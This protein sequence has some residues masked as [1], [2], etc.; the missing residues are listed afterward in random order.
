M[1]AAAPGVPGWIDLGSPDLEATRAFYTGLFGWTAHTGGEEFGGYTIFNLGDDPVAGAGPLFSPDQPTVWTTYVI[2]ADADE[3]AAKVEANGGKVLMAPGDVGENGRM[4]MFMDPGGAMFSVWQPG[5]MP[6]AT[7]FNT[8]GALCWNEVLTRD[9]DGMKAFYGA[10]FGWGHE[11]SQV[12]DVTYT[13]WLLGENRVAGM[14]PMDGMPAEMPAMWATCFAVADT[15]A[16]VAKCVELGGSVQT[17]P[18]D[19]PQ[20]RY[21]VLSDPHGGSFQVIKM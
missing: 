3:T 10:V 9:P 11:D 13:V 8:P 6:G 7:V 2:T 15:D 5:T 20:G 1:T 17:P 4:A 18:T 14:M 12:G 16:T 21:A 19:I